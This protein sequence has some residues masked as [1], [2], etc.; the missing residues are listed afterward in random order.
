MDTRR[1]RIGCE[2][3]Y[4]AEIPTPTVFQVQPS[5]A[6]EVLVADESWSFEPELDVRRYA[7]L[8][9]NPCLAVDRLLQRQGIC[10][11]RQWR[12]LPHQLCLPLSSQHSAFSGLVFHS[13]C[14][15]HG[16]FVR[17]T[18]RAGLQLSDR[19]FDRG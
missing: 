16:R 5:L 10:G 7:D 1:L 18:Q 15:R 19:P 11:K 9:G 4:H 2:F 3:V 13:A 12:R 6:S 17:D 14:S 8:Y